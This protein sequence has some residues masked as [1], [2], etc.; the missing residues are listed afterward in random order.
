[1]PRMEALTLGVALVALLVAAGAYVRAVFHPFRESVESQ[2]ARI[3]EIGR[4]AE[5]LTEDWDRE[6][7]EIYKALRKTR[8]AAQQLAELER[9][10]EGSDDDAGEGSSLHVEH[11]GGG[12][13]QGLFPMP[14]RVATGPW[15]AGRAG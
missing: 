1:M 2:N 5:Q 12:G 7:A 6:R 9:S 8:R 14:T 13:P 10:D 3:R 11:G 4:T 15:R